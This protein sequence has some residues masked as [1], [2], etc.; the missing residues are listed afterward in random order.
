M[1]LMNEITN[2]VGKAENQPL[3]KVNTALIL[4]FAQ[5]HHGVPPD[6]KLRKLR[7]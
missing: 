2:Q 7:N 3:L 1:E 5:L 6:F 4:C